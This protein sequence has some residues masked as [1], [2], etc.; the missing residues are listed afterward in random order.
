MSHSIP[1]EWWRR[2][3]AKAV[4]PPADTTIGTPP[5]DGRV[6]FWCLIAYTLALLLE[7]HRYFPI[8]DVIHFNRLIAIVAIAAYV[9]SNRGGT[10][11][12]VSAEFMLALGIVF[13]AVL[14]IPGSYWPSAS[15]ET[16]IDFVK[17]LAIAWLIGQTFSSVPRLQVLLWAFALSTIP[18]AVTAIQDYFSGA[19]VRGRIVGFGR[20]LAANPNDL[21][22]LLNLFL[23]LTTYLAMTTRRVSLWLLAWGIIALSIGA[24][25]VTLSRGGFLTLAVEAVFLLLLLARRRARGAIGALAICGTLG[26]MFVPAG[27]VDRIATVMSVESDPTGSSQA[28]W[29]DMS[30]AVDV[31]LSRPIV[32]AGLGQGVLALNEARGPVWSVVH[33][34][35]LNYG[36]DLGVPGLL[37]FVG[38]VWVSFRT[39]RWTELNQ[40]SSPELR[41]MAGCLRVSQL[42]FIVAAIFHPIGYDFYFFYLAGIALALK[43]TAVR[44]FGVRETS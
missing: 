7:P 39:T 9:F 36:V 22:L 4:I 33:N 23:P 14:S 18:I 24:V 43:T 8:L 19:M 15:L 34:A 5:K 29:G 11:R 41:L 40:G 35:Y 21:A 3:P 12:P 2:E 10:S 6:A 38:L 31:M 44:Q 42:G 17:V 26:A 20:N 27:Y 13:C 25:L 32:G 28:R 30:T 16:L 37:L 1:V